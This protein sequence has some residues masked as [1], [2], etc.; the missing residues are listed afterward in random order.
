MNGMSRPASAGPISAAKAAPPSIRL[1]ALRHQPLVLADEL[2]QDRPLGREVRRHEAAEQRDEPEQQPEAEHS[3][4]CSSGIEARIGARAKSATSIVVREPS[5]CTS[6]PLGIPRIAI[7]AISAARTSAHLPRRARRHEHE[8]RQREVRHARPEDRDDLGGDERADGASSSTLRGSRAHRPSNIKR[9]YGFVKYDVDMP[10]ISDERKTERREQILAGARR[11]FAENGYEG[12]TV[13][14]LEEATGLSRGA[15]FNY[16]ASKE[17][18]FVELAVRGHGAHVGAL[19]QRGPRGGRAR[20]PRA[21][22][23]LARRLPRADPAR[24]HGP[25]VP[26]TDRGAAGG[27]RSRQPRPGRGSAARGRVPRRPRARA[28]S[29]CS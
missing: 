17:D 10:K 1:F 19:G 25:G 4:A 29:G 6:T 23:G 11:C 21:R 16:F 26:R 7:G 28:R 13:A 24:A 22:P 27:R 2:G 3:G 8:P 18:L 12:A 15:I 14:R 20:D 9:P 5:R